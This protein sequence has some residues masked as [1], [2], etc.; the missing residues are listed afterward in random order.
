MFETDER[1]NNLG[2]EIEDLGCCKVITHKKWGSKVFVGTILTSAAKD[3]E[4][5]VKLMSCTR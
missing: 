3:H 2:F 1:Y 4:I 5:I